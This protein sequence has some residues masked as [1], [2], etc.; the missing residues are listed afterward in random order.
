MDTNL[1]SSETSP[2]HHRHTHDDNND[3]SNND[4]D[5][6]NN[7]NDVHML[8]NIQSELYNMGKALSC[9]L[10]LSTVRSPVLLSCLHAFCHDCIRTA[11]QN[12]TSNNS[13]N[14]GSSLNKTSLHCPVC[15]VPCSKRSMVS[16]NHLEE[17]VKGYKLALRSFGLAPVVYDKNVGMTQIEEEV[18][19]SIDDYNDD[20]DHDDDHNDNGG[21]TYENIIDKQQRSSSNESGMNKKKPGPS[22]L[23]C[24]EHLEVS[25]AV[26]NV[27]KQAIRE[28]D[29]EGDNDNHSDNRETSTN[30]K[31]NTHS[32]Q[33]DSPIPDTSSVAKDITN[34][35]NLSAPPSK[36]IMTAQEKIERENKKKKYNA[37]LKDQ[38]RIFEVNQNALVRAAVLKRNQQSLERK[39]DGIHNEG[40]NVDNNDV[41]HNLDEDVNV[42]NNDDDQNESDTNNQQEKEKPSSNEENLTQSQTFFSVADESTHPAEEVE[43]ESI[44]TMTS[45]RHNLNDGM[46]TSQEAYEISTEDLR[47]K[48]VA[49]RSM[50]ELEN[51]LEEE[52]EAVDTDT[53]KPTVK[54]GTAS[55]TSQMSE[56]FFTAPSQ[57]NKQWNGIHEK[58][59][60]EK[61]TN[62]AVGMIVHVQARTWPGVNKPGG[63]AKITKVHAQS[64]AGVKYDVSYILGGKE[65]LVDE[66]FIR[67]QK[68]IDPTAQFEEL[69]QSPGSSNDS[70][71]NTSRRSR[72][73]G[74]RKM[75]ERW[76][77]EIDEEMKRNEESDKEKSP[78]VR[79]VSPTNT[80]N[81]KQEEQRR[82]IT[83]TRGTKRN[84][85]VDDA[86]I[87]T[88]TKRRRSKSRAS[89]K[90]K[91]SYSVDVIS[92]G[93]ELIRDL[94]KIN[95]DEI[96]TLALKRYEN[97]LFGEA[98][99]SINIITSSISNEDQKLLKSFCSKFSTKTGKHI[100]ESL[101]N[102]FTRCFFV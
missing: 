7:K 31:N 71:S 68:D 100:E 40:S 45:K 43:T 101:S 12:H 2:Q 96:R 36:K 22:L 81:E 78:S 1:H 21:D 84:S 41:K 70:T 58:K 86:A 54:Q 35:T 49:D 98:V 23:Q 39:D 25:R 4:I 19:F 9:P 14:N 15:K 94:K 93:N 3:N 20:D 29:Q 56:Q 34:N 83:P 72:R 24:Y 18:S 75:V 44:I 95:Y 73:V 57:N 27:L 51:I 67:L 77:Q 79:D 90:E 52:L 30:I 53:N 76:V 88:A 47:E 60:N 62:F 46:M 82:G 97:I 48:E 69:L 6:N 63:A 91:K 5:N 50:E 65:K 13:K 59:S 26:R 87:P 80:Q 74:E 33:S 55:I 32:R 89:D 38:D 11:F 28:N 61:D 8:L 42:Q 64:E 37:W 66:S 99:R 16:S 10:C 102:I 92:E 17:L 85:S